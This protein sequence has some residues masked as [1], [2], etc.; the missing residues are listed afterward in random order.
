MGRFALAAAM[1]VL[2]LP[3]AARAE[4][5]EEL[6]LPTRDGATVHVEIARPDGDAKVPVILTYSPYNTLG[7][8][9]VEQPRQRRPVGRRR[10]TH[11]RTPT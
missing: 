7:A 8:S 1:A 5:L 6:E 11:A 10:A 3:A 2:A 9:P 4:V